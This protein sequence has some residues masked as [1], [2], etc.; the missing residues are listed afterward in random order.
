MGRRVATFQRSSRS[1]QP[2][3]PLAGRRGANP[4]DAFI[5]AEYKAKGLKPVGRADARTLLRRVYF[6]LIGLPPTPAEQEAFLKDSSPQAYEKVVDRL[7][8]SEQHG[9]R[10]A[11]RWLDVLR[12]A[13]VDERMIAAPGIHLWR[14]WVVNALNSDMPYDHL[15]QCVTQLTGALDPW[16]ARK[17]RLSAC[18]QN[19]NLGPMICSPSD[20]SHAGLL[21][22]TARTMRSYGPRLRWETVSTAFMGMTVGCAKCHDH[23]YDPIKQTDFYAMKAL[24][25]PL[26]VKKV[27][28]G[29]PAEI[30]AQGKVL[31]EAARKRAAVE[32]PLNDLIAPYKNKLYDERVAMLPADI[33]PIIRKPEKERTVGEQKIA[34]DYFPILRIDTDRFLAIMPAAQR[35]QYQDS[36]NK[37]TQAGSGKGASAIPAFWTVEVDRKKELEKT[38]IL[39]SGDP[40]RPEKDHEVLPGWPFA[41]AK[42]DPR[43]GRIEAFSDWLI[44][45]GNPLFVTR[46][47]Q[48]S[49][50]MALW[51]RAAEDSQRFRQIGRHSRE[52]AFARLAGGGIRKA[53]FQHERDAPADRHLQYL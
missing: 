21:F 5:A 53:R 33:Q 14:D 9:V 30:F 29:T 18:G 38:Y 20:F 22:V 4:I 17:W 37:L 47:R 19:W 46:G 10:F 40:E 13:D 50:A 23:M 34:D 36:Q 8:A 49:L 32:G 3:I 31:D 51:R 15:G 35:K 26:V 44:A 28:L 6:D 43:E 24:F 52:P 48:S 12:Y 11:R 25:D 27:L 7:L 45:S 1:W 2:Q 42:P 16:F 41:P 39:T